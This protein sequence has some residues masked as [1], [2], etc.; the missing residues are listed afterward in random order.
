MINST[1]LQVPA[2]SK[3]DTLTL[4]SV[5]VNGFDGG[6]YVRNLVINGTKE[7]LIMSS[8]AQLWT[9]AVNEGYSMITTYTS[10][11]I[12]VR[13]LNLITL[14]IGADNTG[15]RDTSVHA[16]LAS[17]TYSEPVTFRVRNP[18]VT[19][20]GESHYVN[21]WSDVLNGRTVLARGGNVTIGGNLQLAVESTSP[22]MQAGSVQLSQQAF[23]R[24]D[25]QGSLYSASYLY[26]AV[27]WLG[28]VR[29]PW[30]IAL[31]GLIGL[32]WLGRSKL[33]RMVNRSPK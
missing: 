16:R 1:F 2:E 27:P 5:A 24:V 29:S 20:Q 28:I 9:D 19:V 8:E 31:V 23:A 11:T 26:S 30:N 4:D 21:A 3:A 15:A 14:D 12:T 7:I 13:A 22:N 32:V 25:S 33:F 10:T 17:I 6:L 18:V